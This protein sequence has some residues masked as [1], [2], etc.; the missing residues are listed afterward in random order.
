MDQAS[1]NKEDV[2]YSLNDIQFDFYTPEEVR[3]ESIK[4]ITSP[5]V[6]N[7]LGVAQSGSLHDGAMGVSAFDRSSNC[8]VCKQNTEKC[9][10]HFGH[11]ELPVAVYH[12]FMMNQMLKLLNAKCFNC[13]KL[14]INRKDI[15]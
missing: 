15:A 11:I 5:M 14:K 3:R 6:Y 4:P 2:T 8:E 7:N 9:P 13:H 12:P 1:L 10:G